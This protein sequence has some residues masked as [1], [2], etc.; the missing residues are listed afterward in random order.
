MDKFYYVTTYSFDAHKSVFV[1]FDSKELAWDEMERDAK[2]EL[3]L[4]TYEGAWASLP[5]Y[6]EDKESLEIKI[7]SYCN[8]LLTG[9]LETTAM[10]YFVIGVP[11]DN[12]PC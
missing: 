4:Q 10:E 3:A 7:E 6:K 8:N 12:S 11:V 5:N 9:T 2:R 1:P